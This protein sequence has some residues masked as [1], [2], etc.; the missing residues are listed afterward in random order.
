MASALRWVQRLQQAR[1]P[2]ALSAA[3]LEAIPL[4]QGPDWRAV[5]DALDAPLPQAGPPPDPACPTPMP[6]APDDVLRD[7]LATQRRLMD[8]PVRP[9]LWLGRLASL[10]VTLRNLFGSQNEQAQWRALD[11]AVAAAEAAHSLTPLAALLDA[12]LSGGDP[13]CASQPEFAPLPAAVPIAVPANA[14][15]TP[16]HAATTQVL[17]VPMEKVDRLMDLIGEMV[18][19]KN[20]L[21]YL[22]DRAEQVF[23]S[24][25]LSREIKSQYAV[26]NRIAE[27][28]QDGIMQVRM[29]PMSALF[30]RFPRLVRDVAKQLGK[31]VHLLLE[32]DDTEADK[33]IVESLGD[34]LIHI[35]RNSLDHGI[36]SPEV[37]QAAGKPALGSLKVSARQEGDRVHITVQ[38]DGKGID[39]AVVKLKAFEKGLIDEARLETLSDAE[40]VQLVFAAGFS[41]AAAVTDLSGRGVGMDVVRASIA[42]MGGTVRL[43]SVKGEGTRIELALPL[44]VTVSSVMMV[45][46]AGQRFG[47]PMDAVVETVRVPVA[48]IHQV[49]QRQA[50]VLRNQL[51]PLFGADTLL[52]LDRPPQRNAHD[53]YAVLLVRAGADIMGLL[54]DGFDQT[55]DIILKPLEGPLTGLPGFAGTALLGDGS[56]LLVLDVAELIR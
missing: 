23:G 46:L 32:G 9:E 37:R 29:L 47:V 38:D 40:A 15:A 1:L 30:Q 56:V 51:V 8:L 17:K 43:S 6:S 41:T 19:A 44:S 28:M 16:V 34:P 5:R 55:V 52:R 53:E 39:P 21:P 35:L 49:K 20:A 3:L 10:H 11:L 2:D 18:V 45:Y 50:V 24:R 12:Y 22:A 54:V 48:A 31:Q 7:L 26:I 4:Q 25:E 36:E 13:V 27:E 42:K 14:P 33:N